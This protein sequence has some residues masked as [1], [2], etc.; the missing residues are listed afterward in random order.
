MSGR[1]GS[2]LMA[3]LIWSLWN[4]DWKV[5]SIDWKVWHIE[6]GVEYD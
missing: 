2:D 5:R 3:G 4:I 1:G 6:Q